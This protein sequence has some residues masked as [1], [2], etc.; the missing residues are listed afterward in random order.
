MML[1]RFVIDDAPIDDKS[2]HRR[3][4][5]AAVPARARVRAGNVRST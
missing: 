5:A 3:R 4:P 1:F 2:F